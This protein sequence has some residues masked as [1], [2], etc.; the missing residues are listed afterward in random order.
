M[1]E[2]FRVRAMLVAVE[3]TRD[4]RAVQRYAVAPTPP[5]TLPTAMRRE[6]EWA[7]SAPDL[8]AYAK[9]AC[10]QSIHHK[11]V[12]VPGVYNPPLRAP[13]VKVRLRDRRP[14]GN[15]AS[16]SPQPPPHS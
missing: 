16:R 12:Y 7:K 2:H 10:T 6:E 15:R 13:S 9:T 14:R 11:P 8:D 1:A 3:G 5:S 4:E